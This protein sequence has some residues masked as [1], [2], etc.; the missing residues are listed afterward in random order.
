MGSYAAKIIIIVL[1]LIGLYRRPGKFEWKMFAFYTQLSNAA[2][3][4]ASCICLIPG[5]ESI[6][7]YIRYM[8]VCMLMM[9]VF[10]TCCIL[11]PFGGGARK[12]LLETNGPYH[13]VLCPVIST[14]SYILVE[15]HA[16][17]SLIWLPAVLTLAYGMVMLYLNG[18]K[19]VDG[20][21]PFFRVHNQSAVATILW[22]VVLFAAV[23]AIIVVV[24]AVSRQKREQIEK[25]GREQ[26]PHRW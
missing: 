14:A 11:I 3:L 26:R 20:P 16:S 1:E 5:T 8:S 15:R 17:G 6:S 22:M 10:V 7:P 12:L 13:H 25:T 23:A 19:R 18:K 9:T 21:Y 2:A 24:W 4:A